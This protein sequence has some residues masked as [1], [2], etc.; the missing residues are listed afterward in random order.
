M[1]HLVLKRRESDI[2]PP[3]SVETGTF[4][5]NPGNIDG[6]FYQG[7]NQKS[8]APHHRPEDAHG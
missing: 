7:I 3:N 4:H 2:S 6:R 5:L 1:R 8:H